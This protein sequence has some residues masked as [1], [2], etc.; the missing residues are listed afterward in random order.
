ML[1]E[2]DNR[3]RRRSS[4]GVPWWTIATVILTG[5]ALLALVWTIFVATGGD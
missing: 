3:R 5:T 2:K 1:W 4:A